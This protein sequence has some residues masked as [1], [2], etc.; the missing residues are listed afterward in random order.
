MIYRRNPR[1]QMSE[2]EGEFFLVEPDSGEIY[3]LDIVSSGIWRCLSRPQA[4]EEI[5]GLLEAAFPDQA[6][7]VVR[8]DAR[9]ALAEMRA[10]SLLEEQGEAA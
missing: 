7:T 9:R 8:E 6:E 2:L 5:L 4:E 1:V 3:Y 10:Q